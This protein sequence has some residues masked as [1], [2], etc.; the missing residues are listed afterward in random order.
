MS[1]CVILYVIYLTEVMDI[2]KKLKATT[3]VVFDKSRHNILEDKIRRIFRT[4]VPSILR[5]SEKR[6]FSCKEPADTLFL[7]GTIYQEVLIKKCS[8]LA[9]LI[10]V[11]H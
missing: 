10:L 1:P 6:D 3:V 9:N 7:T 2:K 8:D 4:Q 5:F 11:W